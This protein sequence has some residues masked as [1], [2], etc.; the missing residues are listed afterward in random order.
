MVR[1]IP[2]HGFFTHNTY[3][4]MPV[5]SDCMPLSYTSQYSESVN[6]FKSKSKK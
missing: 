3:G 1:A 2:G 6:K 4:I 5:P